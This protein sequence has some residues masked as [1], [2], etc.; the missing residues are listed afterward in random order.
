[1]DEWLFE[2]WGVDALGGDTVPSSDEEP[3]EVVL[4]AAWRCEDQAVAAKVG[5][6]MVPLALSGPAA[7]LTGQGRAFGGSPTEL[8]G[9]WPALVDKALVDGHVTVRVEEV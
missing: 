8:L 3:P 9:L 2:Y 4:R 7:G 6:K 5:R 1:V